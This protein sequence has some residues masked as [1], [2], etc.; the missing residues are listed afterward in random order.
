[1]TAAVIFDMDGVLTDSEPVILAAAMAGLEEYGVQSKPEDFKPFV[2]MGEDRFIGGVAEKYGVEYKVEMK[3]RVYEIYL[4]IVSSRLEVYPG[5]GEMLQKLKAD[6]W[7]MALA[8]SADRIKIE[9]NLQVA[10]IPV[11]VFH[12]I[13]SGEDVKNKKP[14]PEIF[15]LAAEKLGVDAAKCIVVEDAVNGIRAA[16]AAGMRCIGVAS[17]FPK[18]VLSAENPDYLCK[19]TSDVYEIAKSLR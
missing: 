17:T 4:Q 18:E 15:L 2:G 13:V 1:M 12:A 19:Q 9:A 8:S 3:A 16:K 11:E 7:R 14:H 6:G 5:V 10:G